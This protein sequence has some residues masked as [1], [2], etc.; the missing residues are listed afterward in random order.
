MTPQTK[1]RQI[2]ADL[3]WF[4]VL[5]MSRPGDAWGTLHRR[6]PDATALGLAGFPRHE[7]SACVIGREYLRNVREE[8]DRDILLNL[9]GHPAVWVDEGGLR[10]HLRSQIRRDFA[11][12]RVVRLHG[13]ILSV[14]ESRL[15]ALTALAPPTGH[16]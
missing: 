7:E 10:S 5:V 13:W 15:C 11:E 16:G 9:L 1:R 4:G 12:E 14:T 3:F 2:L 8:A 6:R